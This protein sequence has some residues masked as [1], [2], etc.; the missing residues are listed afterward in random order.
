[1]YNV[2]LSCALCCASTL[3]GHKRLSLVV[4]EFCAKGRLL[5]GC[6]ALSPSSTQLCV[7]GELRAQ[8]RLTWELLRP[9]AQC[10]YHEM[11]PLPGL[12]QCWG[13]PFSSLGKLS[14]LPSVQ[15][16]VSK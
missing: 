10:E 4:L 8:G 13:F 11:M 16:A 7:V 12:Q 15:L 14:K 3:R 9:D 2:I 5:R 1:M 6:P